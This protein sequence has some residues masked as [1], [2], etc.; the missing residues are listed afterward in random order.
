MR[1]LRH[2]DAAAE[3]PST[4]RQRKSVTGAA[5]V[6]ADEARRT[7]RASSAGGAGGDLGREGDVGGSTAEERW[8]SDMYRAKEKGE[9]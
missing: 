4:L 1:T 9:G 7:V 6:D 5:I 2:G 8:A 3:G